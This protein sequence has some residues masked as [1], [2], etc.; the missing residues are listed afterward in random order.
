M[1]TS[2]STY[3][4]RL[5]DHF[6]RERTAFGRSA[7]AV[8][9]TG[10]FFVLVFQPYLAT[11]AGLVDLD[12]ELTAQA[13]QIEIV[14]NN[15]R[16]A[17]NGIQRASDYM[18]DASAYQALYEDAESWVDNLDD[19]QLRY[20]RQARNLEALR[21]ALN[22]EDQAA[23]QPGKV[24]ARHVAEALT[25]A[26]PEIMSAYKSGS[27][28]FFRLGDDWLRCLVAEKLRPIRQRLERVL[29]DR[30]DSNEYTSRLK[31]QI[32]ENQEKY[33]DGMT[34]AIA[35]AEIA[36]WVRTYL[37]E[38]KAIIRRWYEDLARERSQLMSEQ[39]Q[40]QSLLTRNEE[41]RAKLEQRKKEI[42]ESGKLN[43]PVGTLPLAFL[44]LLTLLP[45]ILLIS[46]NMLLRSQARLFELRHEFQLNGPDDE[47]ESDAL[48][49]TLP[50]WLDAPRGYAS[51]LLVM[52]L[53][54]VPAIAALVG[55]GQLMTNPGLKI[56]PLLQNITIVGSVIAASLYAVQYINL[57]RAWL[58]GRKMETREPGS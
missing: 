47:T 46:G 31:L 25:Q 12:R 51:G 17:T 30:T 35:Q 33:T 21:S 8:V 39:E 9:S 50:I 57:Y 53:L 19:I 16:A 41:E 6:Q 54:L 48:R 22:T 43:T 55:V 44:D 42:G 52:V 36:D 56:S 45:L 24:P 38:E 32:R 29:Y 49:L 26:R 7:L 1:V 15:I 5:Y 3:S 13:R 10:V 4:N 18:G 34:A 27:D 11:L 23:W 58:N 20:D 2:L 37:E 28:C 14:Q 40:Q